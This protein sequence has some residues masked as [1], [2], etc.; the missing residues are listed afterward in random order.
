MPGGS[1]W[2]KGGGIIQKFRNEEEAGGWVTKSRNVGI[3]ELE[4]ISVLAKLTDRELEVN[5]YEEKKHSEE[6][7]KLLRR[8]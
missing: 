2:Q 6:E 3:L 8:L 7:C 4:H 1:S 5:C